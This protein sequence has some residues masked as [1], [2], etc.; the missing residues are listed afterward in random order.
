MSRTEPIVAL[1]NLSKAFGGNQA[2]KDVDFAVNKGEI[3]ALAGHNGAGKSTI[4]KILT[5]AV[6]PDHGDILVDG[7]V[8]TLKSRRAA[9]ELGFAIVDQEERLLPSLSVLENI[10]LGLPFPRSRI[11]LIDWRAV[12]RMVTSRKQELGMIFP[13]SSQAGELSAMHQRLAEITRALLTDRRIVIF[14]EATVA[15]DAEEREKFYAVLRLLKKQGVGIVVI[16]HLLDEVL[17]LSDRV[18]VMR[19]GAIVAEGVSGDFDRSRLFEL[20]SGFSS[21]DAIVPA[22]EQGIGTSEEYPVLADVHGLKGTVL[23]NVSL[24]VRHGEVLGLAGLEGSGKEEMIAVLAGLVRPEAG[25]IILDGS[26]VKLPSPRDAN[27]RGI[28]LLPS[29]RGVAGLFGRM[30]LRFNSTISHL[31]RHRVADSIPLLSGS[32]LDLYAS[33]AVRRLRIN[34]SGL[35]EPVNNLSGGNQQKVM[36]AR[37]MG[38]RARVLLFDEPTQGVDVGVRREIYALSRELVEQ[39]AS[40]VY[41]SSDEEEL[42]LVSDR[43]IVFREGSVA[44]E[45]TGDEITAGR[46]LDASF[47]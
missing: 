32:K 33:D 30:G 20:I 1:R 15:L 7:S 38:R 21:S 26:P 13:L 28:S 45:F 25:T 40:I 34:T 44:V 43:V 3:V 29:D 19:G 12:E 31:N 2:V 5:G 36:F 18:V 23:R 24:Q 16:T 22:H 10:W 37:I 4:V 35:R 8:V 42:A 46:I 27:R 14:D 6:Q 39:G 47:S 17:T 11:G 9:E 41:S